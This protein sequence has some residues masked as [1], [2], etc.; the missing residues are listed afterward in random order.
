M[1][2]Y[3]TESGDDEV[4]KK[5]EKGGKATVEQARKAI[6][7]TKEAGIKTWTYW[8]IG[9]IGDNEKTINKTI[10]LA[11][12]LDADICNFSVAAPYLGTRFYKTAKENNWIVDE[13]WTAFD[14]NYSA[15]VSQPDCPV[16]LVKKM[17]RKAYLR[18]YFS[19]RGIRFV[20][21]SF[22]LEYIGY[23]FKTILDHVR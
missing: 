13:R 4:L 20:W 11:C 21:N 5:N 7:W 3:G 22:K 17:Q 23:F 19:W 1:I 10:D 15:Q 9:L 2:C 18:W 6:K 14:Q 16:E 8:M 12:E